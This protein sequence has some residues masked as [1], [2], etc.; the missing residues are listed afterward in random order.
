MFPGTRSS[1]LARLQD[2]VP[3]AGSSYAAARNHDRGPGQ[4]SSVSRLSPAIRRRLITEAEVVQAVVREHG[5]VAAEKFVMEVCWRTYWKGWLQHR[6]IVWQRYQAQLEPLRAGI[7]SDQQRML[8]R[9]AQHDTG[10]ACLDDWCVELETTG[11]LHN[12]VRMW[13]ASIWIFTLRLPWQ[14]G[15]VYFYQHLLDADPASNTL[16]WRWVAGLQTPGKHYLARADNI[17]R[18]TDGRYWPQGQLDESATALPAD[19]VPEPVTFAAMR[20]PPQTGRRTGLLLST[21]DL[22]AESWP[23]PTG[24]DICMIAA[25]DRIGGAP[26]TAKRA[27][28]E[29]ALADAI[30]RAATH[31]QVPV[32]RLPESDMAAA[33]LEQSALHHIE[34]WIALEAP[35]GPV[36]DRWAALEPPLLQAGVVFQLLRRDW[37]ERAWPHTRQGF[38]RFKSCIP[39]LV[40]SLSITST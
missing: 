15:A 5:T 25:V 34:Q 3:H 27:Y 4:P 33:M 21:E 38:F 31:Y 39:E 26:S 40:Q 9:I 32:V 18:Y 2:F 19:P 17:A 37:D 14:L 30:E 12:H 28:V 7:G 24:L 11:Y 10:I 29:A 35:V 6:P 13:F 36:A 16:S 23:L 8:Q 22:H 1:A 20:V